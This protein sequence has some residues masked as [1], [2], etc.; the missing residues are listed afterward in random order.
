LES[1]GEL[2][3]VVL[4][5]TVVGEELD[6]GTIDLD[7]S[8]IPLDQVLL[9]AQRREAPVLGDDNLLPAGE[10]VLRTAESFEGNGAV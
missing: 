5:R 6:V 10:L 2:L 8:S 4:E 7:V 1:V 3:H 9:A